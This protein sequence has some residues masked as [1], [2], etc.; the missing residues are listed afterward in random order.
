MDLW[1][2]TF[3]YVKGNLKNIFSRNIWRQKIK[4]D[5]SSVIPNL[6]ISRPRSKVN[7]YQRQYYENY[8]NKGQKKNKQKPIPQFIQPFTRKKRP[9][10]EKK[11]IFSWHLSICTSWHWTTICGKNVF[12]ICLWLIRVKAV[13]LMVKVN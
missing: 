7:Y 3:C 4:V 2:L 6:Y 13:W 11:K 9:K 8:E 12:L 10:N 1:R 5:H